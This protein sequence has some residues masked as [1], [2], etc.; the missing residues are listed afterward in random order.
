MRNGWIV[1]LACVASGCLGTTD[2][3][4]DGGA[5]AG[6]LNAVHGLVQGNLFSARDAISI[7]ATASGFDF[8]GP[9]TVVE[10]TDFPS[11]CQNQ[12]DHHGVANG[13]LLFFALAT[14]SSGGVAAA[15]TIPGTY[16]VVTSPV[17]AGNDVELF[18]QRDDASCVRATGE[19]ASSGTVTVNEVSDGGVSGTFDVSF[20]SGDHL[21]GSFQAPRCG[22]FN[23]NGTP[24][25]TC[26]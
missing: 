1:A 21:T 16:T 12:A 19:Q 20:S 18:Y 13:Q 15:I 25:G 10:I 4:P 6:T 11:A 22:A 7:D 23:P 26:G 14:V 8:N 17:P 2:H 3:A 9:S 24:S 5:D